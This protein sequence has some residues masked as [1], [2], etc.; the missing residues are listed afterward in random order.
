MIEIPTSG[1][2]HHIAKCRL[3]FLDSSALWHLELEETPPPPL[4]HPR[5]GIPR[6]PLGLASPQSKDTGPGRNQGGHA[7]TC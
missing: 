3:C 5:G 7:L 1:P 4:P 6:E 2:R